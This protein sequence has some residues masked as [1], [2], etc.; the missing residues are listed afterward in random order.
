M[1]LATY[2]GTTLNVEIPS[3]GSPTITMAALEDFYEPWKDFLRQGSVAG[4]M[5]NKRFPQCFRPIAG[6]PIIPSVKY[7]GMIFLRNDFGWRLRLPDENVTLIITGLLAL[8]STT[9]A[10]H[11]ERAGKT[12]SILGLADFVVGVEAVQQSAMNYGHG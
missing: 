8:Q 12:G 5:N 10:F 1:P 2:N 7:Q 4:N 11:R 6:D 3:T 9:L